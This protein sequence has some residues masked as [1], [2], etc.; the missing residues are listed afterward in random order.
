MKQFYCN[1]LNGRV[2]LT[3]ER[4]FHIQQRHP[5]VKPFVSKIPV[6]LT[7][8]NLI[9]QK[10]DILLFSLHF[11]EIKKHIVVVVKTD[12]GRNFILTSYLTSKIRGGETLW[13]KGN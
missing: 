10:N 11:N 1:F 5:D 3:E 8:P 7:E 12:Y 2:E 4:L 6:V 13:S 9:R